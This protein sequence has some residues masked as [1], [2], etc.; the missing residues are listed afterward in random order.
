M[1]AESSKPF[2]Q[3]QTYPHGTSEPQ[4]VFLDTSQQQVLYG[5]PIEDGSPTSNLSSKHASTI[6]IKQSLMFDV[7]EN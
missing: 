5:S 1:V 4:Q 6:A 2:I 7:L 3:M